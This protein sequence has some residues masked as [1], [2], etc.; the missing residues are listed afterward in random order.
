MLPSAKNN[1]Q[2]QIGC[3][4]CYLDMKWYWMIFSCY[5]WFKVCWHPLSL[6]PCCLGWRS[7]SGDLLSGKWKWEINWQLQNTPEHVRSIWHWSLESNKLLFFQPCVYPTLPVTFWNHH[8]HG[9][10]ITFLPLRFQWLWLLYQ[11]LYTSY[12]H[13]YFF[14]TKLLC[15]KRREYIK[16]LWKS[17]IITL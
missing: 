7:F 3:E 4:W 2:H 14:N 5:L 15:R 9:I 1:Y 6:Y 10:A 8:G 13:R 11:L 12:Y 17:W 16:K